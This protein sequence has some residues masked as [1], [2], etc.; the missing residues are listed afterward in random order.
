MSRAGRSLLPWIYGGSVAAHVAFAAITLA[1]PSAKTNEAVAIELAEIKK[2]NEPPRPPPPPPPP[3][4]K[5]EKPKPPPPRPVAQSQAKLA[6]EPAKV[7]EAPPVELGADGFADLGG[8]AL[9]GGSGEGVAVGPSP[10]AVAAA[11]SRSSAAPRATARKVEHLAAALAAPT[12]N[13]PVMRPKRKVFVSPKY[14]RQAQLAEIEG[15]V[16]V[17]VQVDDHGRVVAARVTSG[18]GYGLDEVALKAAQEATFEPATLC[19]RPVP[20]RVVL[21]IRFEL[22]T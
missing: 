10:A 2:K 11:V 6:P 17:E 20:G 14:T 22:G 18:L 7:V 5:E 8:V 4:P 9:G 19:G 12:C 1:L 21:P 3:P 15:V 16:K 13:E